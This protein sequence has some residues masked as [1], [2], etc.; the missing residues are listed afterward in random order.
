MPYAQSG[1]V[2][3]YYADTGT[4]YPIVFV[5]EFGSD[6]REWETQVRW[7]SREYRCIA[8]NARG[9]P[10]S[11]V[12]TEEQAYGYEHSVADIAAVMRH[13][14][15]AKAHVV[16]LSMGA[17]A[18]L[19][20]GLRHPAMASALVVAGCG[21]GSPKEVRV[22]FRQQ[23]DANADAFLEAGS[24]AMAETMG[25]SPT[26]VQLQ[27]KDPRGWQEFVDHLA[28]HSAQGSALT[29]RRYQGLR[30]SLVDFTAELKELKIPVLLAVGDEDEPCLETNLFLKRTIPSAGLW[31]APKTGHAINLEEPAAF[32]RAV[33]DFFGTV[34]RGRWALRDP[35]AIG[36]SVLGAVP[37]QTAAPKSTA[38]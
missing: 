26:R 17:Y 31:M 21:S 23:C 22:A 7:F 33:Q 20:F 18:T 25:L 11:D 30:P 9:Y 28:A 34:E 35:R 1:N 16:G 13:L 27:I 14:G 19:V 4:G 2:K 38:A 15:V 24:P 6:L 10:P 12:P 37:A 29:L 36:G 5:H 3:L 8:F 32:N